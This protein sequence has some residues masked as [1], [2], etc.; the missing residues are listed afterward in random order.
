MPSWDPTQYAKFGDHRLRPALDLIGR[1]PDIGPTRIVD[2][3]CGPGEITEMLAAR[4]PEAETVGLDSSPDM[5][6]KAASLKGRA[7]FVAGDVAGWVAKPKVD[8]LFSNACL[9]W[10]PDHD[11]LF[12]RLIEQVAPGGTIAIQMPHNHD[13]PSHRI[14]AELAEEV[15]FK[16]PLTGKLRHDPVASSDAYWRTMKPLVAKLDV[17]EIDYLQALTGDDPV[18]N[19]TMGTALRPVLDALEETLKARFIEKYRDGLRRAYP[20]EAEGSTLF[21]FR[22]LFILAER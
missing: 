15:P 6:K 1:I 12:P 14:I 20:R 16:A 22:R 11:R 4:W 7:R 2:L 18:L 8:L 10:L 17:W 19:W 13:Q 21:P 5:L 3:G 9:Q